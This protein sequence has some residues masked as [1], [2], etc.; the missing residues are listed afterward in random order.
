[1]HT[2]L[3]F[4][5]KK[6]KTNWVSFSPGWYPV[7]YIADNSQLLSNTSASLVLEIDKSSGLAVG[8]LEQSFNGKL[9]ICGLEIL[10][11]H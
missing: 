9:W 4:L 7:E 8:E 1:M 5:L 2:L 10:W 11:I 6:G 3:W